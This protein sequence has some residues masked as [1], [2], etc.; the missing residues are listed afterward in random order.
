MAFRLSEGFDNRVVGP[1][2]SP[3]QRARVVSPGGDI[4]VRQSR[5]E[6]GD[7]GRIPFVLD[8]KSGSGGNLVLEVVMVK[9]KSTAVWAGMT[10]RA[11]TEWGAR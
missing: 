8:L 6:V 1:E 7:A 10:D 11:M 2:Y 9:K 4:K 3:W 5:H